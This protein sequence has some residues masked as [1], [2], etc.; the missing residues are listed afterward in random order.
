M[1]MSVKERTHPAIAKLLAKGTKPR[2]CIVGGG[3][4]GLYALKWFVEEGLDDVVLFEQTNSIGGV[5]VYTPDKPGGCFKGTRT[6]ASK[7]YLHASDFPMPESYG[8][9]PNHVEVLNFLKDYANHFNLHPYIKL[10]QTVHKARKTEDGAQWKVVTVPTK[11]G[12]DDADDGNAKKEEHYFDILVCCSGQHQVPRSTHKDHPFDQFTGEMMHSHAYKKP[13]K[14]MKGKTVLVVGGGESASDVAA[15]V[16]EKAARTILAIRSGTWFQDRTVGA[17]QPADMVFTKHQRLL[18]FSDFQSWLV[19]IGRYTMIEMMWGKGGS[20]LKE[21][22][23]SCAYFHGFLNKSRD[24]VDKAALGKVVARRGVERIEGKRVWFTNESKPEDVDL[25]IFATGYLSNLPFLAPELDFTTQAYKLV[26]DPQ[27]PTLC[28]VGTARP[29]IG[30]IPALGELQARWAVKVYTGQVALPSTDAMLT[31][32]AADKIRHKRVFPADDHHLPQLVN[33]WEYS[34]EIAS[35][36]G[37]KPD[38]VRW[39]FRNPFKWWTIISAPWSAHIYR[40]EE[41]KARDEAIA[42]INRTWLPDHYSFNFFNK[43]MLAFD[44]WLVLNVVGVFCLL[45]VYLFLM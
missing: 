6:T 3:W 31:Q 36:F 29:M 44:L 16:C 7:S 42:N 17:N 12:Q 41:P 34:D 37:A 32:L 39:F 10:Q 13:T 28:Y 9:F 26:F 8:H 45:Y 2:V 33:H 27:D 11:E 20:G 23:P 5:W 30:S 4:N 38:L 40:V 14:A 35:Y 21:W 18:G 24:I 15:E 22:Q 25:I 43:A 19:W 1:E